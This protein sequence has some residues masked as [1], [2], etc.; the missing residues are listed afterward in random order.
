METGKSLLTTMM[1]FV[2]LNAGAEQAVSV[3]DANRHYSVTSFDGLPN[4]TI[5]TNSTIKAS[6]RLPKAKYCQ[7]PASISIS[8]FSPASLKDYAASWYVS[9]LEQC[10]LSSLSVLRKG[11]LIIPESLESNAQSQIVLYGGFMAFDSGAVMTVHHNPELSFPRILT[12]PDRSRIRALCPQ[13][14]TMGAYV[15]IIPDQVDWLVPASKVVLVRSEKFKNCPS[16]EPAFKYHSTLTVQWETE[17]EEEDTHI[18]YSAVRQDS[19]Y[20]YSNAASAVLQ[21]YAR[22]IDEELRVEAAKDPAGEAARTLARL[23]QINDQAEYDRE[24]GH[25]LSERYQSQ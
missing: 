7:I 13:L 10:Q 8:A 25:L 21:D 1:L 12:A 6:I 18:T 14:E 17:T 2:A 22:F 9:E 16:I 15:K 19:P 20:L 4:I 5:V 3:P 23:D 24:V 11:R